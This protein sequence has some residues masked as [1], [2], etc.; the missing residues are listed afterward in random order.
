MIYLVIVSLIWAFSFGMI[1]TNLTSL[2]P[3]FVSFLRLFIS[4]LIF[5]PFLRLK[6]IFVK[7]Q[8]YL[9]LTGA[10]QFGI[11]YT[12]YI[13]AYQFLQAYEIALFTIFTPVYITLI[14]DLI[15][16]RFNKL[17]LF[18]SI[19][20]VFGTAIIIYKNIISDYFLL[21]FFLVQISNL[22]FAFGQVLYSRIMKRMTNITHS[23]IFGLLYIGAVIVALLASLTTT[24][25]L[26]ITITSEQFFTLLYL[27]VVSSGIA[28]YLWNIGVTKVNK[29][30]LAIFN[31]LK[32]PLAVG[33]SILFFDESGDPLK[34]II[35]GGLI[36]AALFFNESI[37]SKS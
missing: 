17:F 27:G 4:L 28:F 18:T 36:I 32:I 13:Y 31:N 3:N 33:V 11:M 24:D 21:G 23:S 14:N 34:L 9:I 6:N 35:G 1:K 29:G 37:S 8:F 19:I 16:K 10:I 12:S 25:Y 7:D 15:R 5:L 22:C 26:D 20:A 2:D 30:A